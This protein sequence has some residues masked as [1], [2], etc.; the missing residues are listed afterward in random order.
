MCVTLYICTFVTSTYVACWHG[1]WRALHGCLL[2]SFPLEDPQNQTL[3]DSAACAGGGGCSH[4]PRVRHRQAGIV[5]SECEFAFVHVNGSA[6]ELGRDGDSKAFA[7]DDND[8]EAVE[9]EEEEEEEEDWR[10]I[11]GGRHHRQL[12]QQQH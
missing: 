2:P 5:L 8:E 12:Q 11:G 7:I 10:R 6:A 3:S 1:A 4:D 9:E